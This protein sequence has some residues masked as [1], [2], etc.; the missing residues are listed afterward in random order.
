MDPGQLLASG[1]G[2]SVSPLLVSAVPLH[3]SMNPTDKL[4]PAINNLDGL[5]PANWLLQ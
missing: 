1:T 5:V 4:V 3:F 2:R